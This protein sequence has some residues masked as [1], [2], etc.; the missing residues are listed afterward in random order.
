[1]LWN[2]FA[3]KRVIEKQPDKSF[4]SRQVSD[5]LSSLVRLLSQLR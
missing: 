5:F 1:M 4:L 3:I 2:E